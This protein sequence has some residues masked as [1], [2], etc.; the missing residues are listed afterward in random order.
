MVVFD[1]L[2]PW[3]IVSFWTKSMM[4]LD[5]EYMIALGCEYMIALDS[6]CMMAL[7][8]EC[9]MAVALDE[10]YSCRLKCM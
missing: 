8:D 2:T 1:L 6:E 4:A 3:A 9:M 5:G 7:D 10:I